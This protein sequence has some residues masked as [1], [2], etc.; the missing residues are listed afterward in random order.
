MSELDVTVLDVLEVLGHQALGVELD[1]EV[2]PCLQLPPPTQQEVLVALSAMRDTPLDDAMEELILV[3][4]RLQDEPNA[5][6]LRLRLR[7]VRDLL[8]Q[9]IR[10]ERVELIKNCMQLRDHYELVKLGAEQVLGPPA[11]ARCTFPVDVEASLLAFDRLLDET[12][13]P[14]TA[15]RDELTEVGSWVP[16]DERDRFWWW[17]RD[18]EPRG[19]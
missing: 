8:G 12:C 7:G 17:F 2:F 9:A 6:L 3:A 5:A 19:T 14:L 16:E 15:V 4:H 18:D 11:H 1:D 10:A 13:P